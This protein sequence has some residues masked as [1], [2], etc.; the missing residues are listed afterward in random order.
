MSSNQIQLFWDS[1]HP[2][3]ETLKTWFSQCLPIKFHGSGTLAMSL[4]PHRL[5]KGLGPRSLLNPSP[6][7]SKSAFHNYFLA[8]WYRPE[9]RRRSW[10]SWQGSDDLLISTKAY[11]KVGRQWKHFLI[12]YVHWMFLISY[13]HC[14]LNAFQSNS[15]A[16]EAG[17]APQEASRSPVCGHFSIKINGFGGW[18]VG[19]ADPTASGPFLSNHSVRILF[20][21]ARPR[22]NAKNGF[23]PPLFFARDNSLLPWSLAVW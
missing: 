16:L 11:F 23:A 22:Q 1:G 3:G 7:D 2:L 5:P 18:L 10:A 19:R 6:L 17:L 21:Y 13:V 8:F 9:I 15:M 14:F 20:L 12:S 4:P